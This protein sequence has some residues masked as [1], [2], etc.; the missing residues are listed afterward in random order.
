MA[1]GHQ[2]RGVLLGVT[3]LLVSRVC[4]VISDDLGRWTGFELLGRDGKSLIVLCAY[5]VCQKGGRQG[6]LTAF[7]QQYTIL[8]RKGVDRPDPRR[9]F[10]KDLIDLLD[11]YVA[12]KADI[13]L[14]GDFNESK[15]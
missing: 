1:L 2:A 15:G 7:S 4:T 6:C 14:L 10:I 12:A 13:I 8:R 3:G 5:Q 9:Q 11:P